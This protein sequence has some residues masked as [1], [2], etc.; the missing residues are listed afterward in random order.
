MKALSLDAP[1]KLSVIHVPVPELAEGDL[2]VC[3]KAA[4]TCGTDLKAHRR[5]HPQIPMPGPFGHE[6]SGTVVATGAG[7]PFS[8]GQDVMGV[9]S[10]PCRSCFWCK[11]GQ[12]NLCESIMSSKVLGSYAE[13]LLV[14]ARIAQLNVFEKPD[15]LPFEQAA[16]LEP[17]SCV[18]QGVI[19]LQPKP[20]ERVLIIG[21]GAIGLMFVAALRLMGLT[22]ITLAGRNPARL[23]VGADLGAKAVPLDKARD[24]GRGY[25]AVIECTGQSVIWESSVDYV[26][27]GGRVILFGGTPGGTKVTWDAGRLHYDQITLISPFHFGT[28]AVRLAHSWLVEDRLDLSPLLSGERTLEEASDVFLA[29]EAGEGIKYVFRP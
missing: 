1:G 20:S 3:V 25:D 12:E 22:D 14:P 2:L 8:N 26:R 27:R 18:A 9:H 29:L 23:Q 24:T 6:Y 17:L 28:D 11:A 16:L 7:A 10:A 13:Y 21:P 5:G 19:E 4:T 15:W